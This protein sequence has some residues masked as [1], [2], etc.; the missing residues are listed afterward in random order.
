VRKH[1]ATMSAGGGGGDLE[2]G[3]GSGLTQPLLRPSDSTA[4]LSQL[5]DGGPS[6]GRGAWDEEDGAHSRGMSR[7]PSKGR[8]A[9]GEREHGGLFE[10]LLR[11][12]PSAGGLIAHPPSGAPGKLPAEPVL[13][14][15]SFTVPGGKT[16]AVVGATG[17]GKSSEW[18]VYV[19]GGGGQGRAGDGKGNHHL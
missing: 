10:A 16:L 18:R 11:G 6:R 19:C 14:G 8:L 12:R 7:A 13:K 2:S 5:G 4:A 1:Q 17:S 9:G 3:G 15:V